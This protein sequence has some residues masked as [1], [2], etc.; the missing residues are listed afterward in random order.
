VMQLF[1]EPANGRSPRDIVKAA[2]RRTHPNAKVDYE[3]PNAMVGYQP[4]YGEVADDWPQSSTA[5]YSRVRILVMAAVKNDI[6]LIAF[7]TGPYRAFGPDFG[8]GP[9]SGANLEL[10]M[11]MGVRLQAAAA[12]EIFGNAVTHFALVYLRTGR[13]VEIAMDDLDLDLLRADVTDIVKNIQNDRFAPNL[14]PLCSVCEFQTDCEGWRGKLPWKPVKETR[15]KYSERLRLSYSKMSLFERCPRAYSKLYNERVPPKPQPFFSFGSCIHAVMEEFFDPAS[16][17]KPTRDRMLEILEET[18]RH[19]RIGYR[20]PEEE[21]R[22][23]AQAV[24]QLEMYFNRFVKGQKFRPAYYIEKYFE[25]AVGKDSIMTGFIDRIDKRP[26]GGYIVLDYKTEPTDRTQ[27][28]VDK[29]LQLTLYYWASRE[30]LNLDIR[31]L[32][33][34]MMS[35]DTLITTTRTPDDIPE[36]LDR[37]IDVTRQIRAEEVFA[38][39]KNKYCLSCDHLTG[40]PLEDEIRSDASIR[41]ME[42][43]ESD[44][45]DAGDG[46]FE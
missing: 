3:I 36:L 42:F 44:M 14:G 26:G 29:D 2:I 28:A 4:G 21:E 18:W 20:T 27:E 24:R 25:L 15:E 32:G 46:G 45:D 35:H 33:L 1:S 22:Y 39:R 38:P 10:A 30:F 40:C 37:V 8:P 17:E 23:R 34:F 9:P 6:A 16:R 31:E 12:R 11:D 41:T 13:T 19:F 7:A 5:R 43:M